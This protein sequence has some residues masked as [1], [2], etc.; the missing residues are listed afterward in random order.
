MQAWVLVE[1]TP[2]APDG[3]SGAGAGVSGAERTQVWVRGSALQL[4]GEEDDEPDGETD[5]DA[6]AAAAAA[7]VRQQLLQ[8]DWAAVPVLSL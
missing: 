2:S 6:G 5:E 1:M 4:V 3:A 7:S 8:A